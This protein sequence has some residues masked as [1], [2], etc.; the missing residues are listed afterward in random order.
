[1]I[2]VCPIDE[3]HFEI[4]VPMVRELKEEMIIETNFRID[5]SASQTDWL[6]NSINQIDLFSRRHRGMLESGLQNARKHFLF[7]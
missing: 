3:V 1:M 5:R 4:L 7:G 2:S 6:E